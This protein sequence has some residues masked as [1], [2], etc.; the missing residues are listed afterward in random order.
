MINLIK[1]PFIIAPAFISGGRLY[2]PLI[3]LK[4]CIITNK[5]TSNAVQSTI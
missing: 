3:K 2:M 5:N 1:L 4:S